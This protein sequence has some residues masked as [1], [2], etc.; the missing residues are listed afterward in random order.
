MAFETK[1]VHLPKAM[2][3]LFGISRSEARRCIAQ[4]GVKVDGRTV[5]MFDVEFPAGARPEVQLGKRRIG[6]IE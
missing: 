2:A 4:G 5:E 3:D 1:Q 6:T